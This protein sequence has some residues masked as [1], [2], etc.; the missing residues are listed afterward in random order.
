[1]DLSEFLAGIM[2]SVNSTLGKP[3]FKPLDQIMTGGYVKLIKSI[4]RGYTETSTV[5]ISNVNPDKCIVLLNPTSYTTYKV[6]DRA[7]PSY[8]DDTITYSWAYN[9]WV[10]LKTLTATNFTVDYNKPYSW[11]IIEFY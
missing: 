11:Q 8:N 3:N 5:T 6:I 10:A 1:M 2:Q 4:Q 7:G 9:G